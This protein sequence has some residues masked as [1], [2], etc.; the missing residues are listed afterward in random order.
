MDTQVVLSDQV[1]QLAVRFPAASRVFARYQIDFCCGGRKSL[2]EACKAAHVDENVVLSAINQ[3]LSRDDKVTSAYDLSPAALVRHILERYH[4]P[5]PEELAKV[6]AMA[7]KVARV[8]GARGDVQL[9]KLHTLVKLLREDLLPH[10]QREENIL[11]PLIVG[12]QWQFTTAPIACME[13]QHDATGEILR[14]IR[15]TTNDYQL[16]HGACTTWRA[17]WTSLE[18]LEA[19]LKAHIALENNV[20]FPRVG[21]D[22]R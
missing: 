16:P 4:A 13:Q 21:T 2:A 17:L 22:R 20:L 6:E 11:F 8:H 7:E 10:M 12:G 3:E 15:A 18:N 1:G 9:A 5:L 14:E 19:E